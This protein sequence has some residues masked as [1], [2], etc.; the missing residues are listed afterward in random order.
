MFHSDQSFT[1]MDSSNRICKTAG[2]RT[3]PQKLPVLT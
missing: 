1:G 3:S 2:I